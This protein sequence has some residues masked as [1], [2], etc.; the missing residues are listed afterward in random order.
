MGSLGGQDPAMS[1][2]HAFAR[3]SP[4]GPSSR[5]LLTGLLT[6]LQ[7]KLASYSLGEI[8]HNEILHSQH[9]AIPY[10]AFHSIQN[11]R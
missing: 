11:F 3:R 2:L 9:L 6:A 10:S 5:F 8:L 4:P 7:E 1:V